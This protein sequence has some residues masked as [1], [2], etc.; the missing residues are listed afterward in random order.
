MHCFLLLN[1]V[2]AIEA[3]QKHILSIEH[4]KTQYVI[5]ESLFAMFCYFNKNTAFDFIANLMANLACVEEGRN[6]MLTNKYFDV[7]TMH[8]LTRQCNNHRRKSLITCIKN[9]SFEYEKY[10]TKFLELNVPHDLAKLL[11]NE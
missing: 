11:I 8:L 10:E 5:A 7:I 4:E 6:W 3:G 9:L 1:N 2:S